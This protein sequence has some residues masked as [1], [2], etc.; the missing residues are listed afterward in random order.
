LVIKAS[1]ATQIEA[2]VADLGAARAATLEAAIAR[3]TVI[4]ARA[5]SRLVAL[6][7]SDAGQVARVAAL[8]A[9]ESIADPRAVDPALRAM[10]AREADVASAGISVARAFLRGPR[11]A[12]LVDRLTTVALDPAR[13]EDVRLSAL[14]ALSDLK[15]ATIAPVFDA[16]RNDASDGIRRT[17]ELAVSSKRDETFDPAAIVGRAAES[18]LPE[19]PAGLRRA[20][21]LLGKRVALTQLLRVI[22]RVRERESSEEG[23]RR[24]EWMRVRGAAH[25]A[26]A[27]RGSRIALYDL[28]ESI[29]SA[30]TPLPVEFLAAL[31]TIGDTSCL[32]ALAAACARSM[33]SGRTPRDWWRQHLAAAFRA[34][35]TRERITR[36][37]AVI[38]KIQKRW[39][40]A[41]AELLQEG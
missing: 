6:V 35:V 8:R 30:S 16:L 32:E 23:A 20:V 5:V 1:A 2:L 9:L 38:K 21:P 28:R 7:E 15:P 13:N 37:Q 10:D 29:E 12:T 4:G 25:V 36:R 17:A 27:G 24:A 11:S 26:L 34:I 3:L 19:D 41:L 22:E 40:E 33:R 14:E 39:P 31:S 18:E